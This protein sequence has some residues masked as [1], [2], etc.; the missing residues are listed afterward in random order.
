M[1]DSLSVP[2]EH[3]ASH[4]PP[5]IYCHY[6]KCPRRFHRH[7]KA[8]CGHVRS[9]ILRAHSALRMRRA[10]TSPLEAGARDHWLMSQHHCDGNHCVQ[11]RE[12]GAGE[13]NGRLGWT[14][15]WCCCDQCCC[16]DHYLCCCCAHCCCCCWNLTLWGTPSR[17][18]RKAWTGAVDSCYLQI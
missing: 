6:S 5:G 4:I 16:C 10:R 1:A 9:P 18:K 13:A 17:Q 3:S 11:R 15:T 12:T 8:L 14:R 2:E 7:V